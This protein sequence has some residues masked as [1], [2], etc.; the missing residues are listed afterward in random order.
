MELD[1]KPCTTRAY[2]VPHNHMQVFKKE[3]DRLVETGIL[4]EG[5]RSEWISGTFIVPKKLLPGETEPRVR[6]VSDFRALNKCLK[7]KVYP[8]PR[9]G[10]ILAR[11]TGY[12]FLSKLD[13]SMFFYTFELDDESKELT[14]IATPFGLYRYKR[15]PMGIKVAPDIAQE[16]IEKIMKAI[17]DIEVYIDDIGI[18]SGDWQT[19]MDTLSKVLKQLEDKGFT[20]NPLKCEFG[21]KETDFL[22]HWLTPEG[23]KPLRK[24]IQGILDMEEPKNIGQLQSFLGMVTYYRDMWPRRSHILA[25]LTNLIGTKDFVWADEQKKAFK[26]MKALV[27]RECLLHYPDH[28]KKFI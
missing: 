3:L 14:T 17:D 18:F 23:V 22:G 10:D 4:E 21:V 7:R 15:L 28:S 8:I 12:K 20:V 24:K 1:S 9:I 13:I 26:E 6:W 11:R 16:H 19:H 25:P 27:A 2:T 5:G